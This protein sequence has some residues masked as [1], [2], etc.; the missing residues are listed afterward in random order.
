MA[1]QFF[2]RRPD[3]EDRH[4]HQGTVESSTSASGY[5]SPPSPHLIQQHT[6]K[7]DTTSRNSILSRLEATTAL[8]SFDAS[9]TIATKQAPNDSCRETLRPVV[10]PQDPG[11]VC[12]CTIKGTCILTFQLTPASSMNCYLCLYSTLSLVVGIW[13]DV[14][15]QARPR[16]ER[17]TRHNTTASQ[18]RSTGRHCCL[19]GMPAVPIASKSTSCTS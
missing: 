15:C 18:A 19:C 7:Q 8:S 11:P 10:E 2:G 17:P 1:C 4:N 14:S 9:K 3:Q 16:S 5:C 13:H 12:C 6:I